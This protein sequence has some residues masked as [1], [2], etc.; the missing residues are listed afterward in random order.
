MAEVHEE[1]TQHLLNS[2]RP[3]LLAT[4][5]GA[6][7][8]GHSC[9][10]PSS[11]THGHNSDN[12]HCSIT[13]SQTW[14]NIIR[15]DVVLSRYEELKQAHRSHAL[16]LRWQYWLICRMR[17]P[18]LITCC[19]ITCGDKGLLT[20]VANLTAWKITSISTLEFL[21]NDHPLCIVRCT[22]PI[23]T[24][25]YLDQ[26]WF[27]FRAPTPKFGWLWLRHLGMETI[28]IML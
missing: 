1:A 25:N 21:G 27:I 15:S 4:H 22:L 12:P 26:R 13:Y 19:R 10:N 23:R 20:N 17:T 7:T 14:T 11:E 24:C 8:W 18:H 6:S 2:D 16:S 28:H 3:R 9:W 5:W